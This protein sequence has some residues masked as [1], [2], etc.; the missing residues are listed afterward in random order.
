VGVVLALGFTGQTA[1]LKAFVISFLSTSLIT[2]AVSTVLPAEGPWLFYGVATTA[3]PSDLPLSHTSWPVFLGLR[4]GTFNILTG[5]GSEGIITFP[6]LHA[7]LGVVFACALWSVRSLRLPALALNTV[8][9][10]ATPIEGSHYFA[11][12]IAGTAIAGLCWIAC[13]RATS[14]A[15][16]PSSHDRVATVPAPTLVPEWPEDGSR[17]DIAAAGRR[18]DVRTPTV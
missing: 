12:V 11:D 8:M 3:T 1:R 15:A 18:E 6:S 13:R 2:I 9:I 14:P 5:L 10:A 17:R 16:D 7:A 4:D